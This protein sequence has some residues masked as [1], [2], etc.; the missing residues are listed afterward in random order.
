MLLK[1]Y[2]EPLVRK[3]PIVFPSQIKLLLM[4][5]LMM[6]LLQMSNAQTSTYSRPS[7]WFGVA[8]AANLNFYRGSTQQ[9]NDALT[10]PVA[11]HD[12][13]GTGLYVAPLMEYHAPKSLLGFMLQVGMD[14]KKGKF[15]AVT[16]P[17]NCPADLKTDLS[18]ISI[19]PSL[20]LAPFKGN[21]YLY[22]G[23]RFL[24]N[25]KKSFTYQLGKNPALPAQAENAAVKGDFNNIEKNLI[26]F[27]V[28]TGYDIYLSSQNRRTQ[29]VFSPF[30]AFQPYYGQ[31]PRSIETW[32]ITSVRAGAALKFGVGKKAKEP[33]AVVELPVIIPVV[34]EEKDP[35]FSFTVNAPVNI[36]GERRV[37]EMFPVRN[38]VF[39]DL[40]S[41]AIPDR[42]V[43][44][45]KDQVKGFKEDQ[46]DQFAP[47]NLSGR[48][49]RQ[50]VVYYNILNILGDRM[51]KNP[52]TNINLEGA[53]EKG[54]VDALAMAESVKQY[55]VDV[56]AI[57]PARITTVGRIKPSIPS[58]QP[59]AT[60]DLALLREGDHRVSI[61]TVSP[62]LLMEF[63]SGPAAPL[64]PVELMAVQEAPV[65]SYISFNVN[66]ATEA[67]SSW[68]LEIKNEAG[69]VQYYGPYTTET[70]SIPGKSLLGTKPEGD[71]KV[72]MVG[73]T[74]KG[75]VITKESNVHV[76]LWKAPSIIEG[77][78]FSVIFGFD[79]SK[80][81]GI[82]E[83]YLT[84]IVATK[85]PQGGTVMIHGHTD[86]IGD[87]GY[88]QKLSVARS[89]EVKSILEAAMLK[90]GRSDVKFEVFGFGEDQN[91][92]P[93][94]NKF[95]EE[96]FYN[97]TVIID[98]IPAK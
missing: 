66:G 87:A 1:N 69:V 59:G 80:A 49:A 44:L 7:W 4:T 33:V 56:F 90:A 91:L 40:G 71:F 14:S 46:L 76:I 9:L 8:G 11:F 36:P 94:D 17:C 86:I 53:S 43:L 3:V 24:F 83:K 22:L 27:Q 41:T 39:F 85:I 23:P 45:S 89:N 28:G 73:R 88:N 77:T 25:Q 51:N 13:K 74:A 38:Y 47:K 5:L 18:Y 65:D 70:V 81:I 78:R 48:S 32:N 19:E 37:H 50:M 54:K 29:W 62:E 57:N 35:V 93:F 97:R 42:Y 16:T 82:Y 95:P 96:R 68:S 75:K 60:M 67:F 84:E 52:S 20:R 15:D 63:Q 64:R 6:L 79:E 34:I 12:G 61:E 31:S 72:L 21:F 26:S 55:L 30:A 92:S 98:I 2:T 10:V 58:E